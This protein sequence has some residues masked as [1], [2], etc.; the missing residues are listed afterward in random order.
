MWIQTVRN[1]RKTRRPHLRVLGGVVA[2][3]ALAFAGSALADGCPGDLDGD[4][5]VGASDLS[6]L[7]VSWGE[8]SKS[9]ADINGDGTVDAADLSSLLMS[10]GSC[11]TVPAWA[12]L[13]E[14]APDATVVSDPAAREAI[15]ETGLAWRV[16]DA[17]TGIEMILIPPGTYDMGCSLLNGGNCSSNQ[18]PRHAITIPEAFYIGRYEVTQAEWA[19]EMGTNPS[20]FASVYEAADH[21]VEMVSHDMIQNFLSSSGLRLPTEAEW[22]YAYRAGT[23]TAYHAGPG[24]P[25]GIVSADDIDD[26]AWHVENVGEIGGPTFSTK[27]IGTKAANGFGLHDM[28]GNV[29]EWV[30]DW[31]GYN[32]YSSSPSTDPQGPATGELRVVRGGSWV[33]PPSMLTSSIR[34]NAYPDTVNINLGFRV[35]RNP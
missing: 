7:L 2:S 21:P 5:Q 4:A 28:S 17:G 10:W 20:H 16:R 8:S 14:A 24:F 9:G 3:A 25:D 30:A 31:Y 12:T 19:G 15:A 35:A 32:Y 11:I 13:V 29:W 1:S 26:I 33:T 22:E 34:D 6:M 27:K 23:H 18:F